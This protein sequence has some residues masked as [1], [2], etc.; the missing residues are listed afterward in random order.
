[1]SVILLGVSAY[2]L[3]LHGMTASIGV[4]IGVSALLLG[5]GYFA[6]AVLLPVWSGWMAFAT[7]LGHVMTF[8]IVSILWFLVAIPVGMLLKIIGKKVMDLSYNAPVDS[9][10][11]ERSEK[12]HDFKLLE[13]QF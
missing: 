7:Q 4:F 11:E 6:P 1:M 10:W 12:Y 5:L 3:Y 8:V 9:Y 2:Q 13:R